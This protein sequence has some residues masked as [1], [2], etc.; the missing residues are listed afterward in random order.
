MTS[1]PAA[2]IISTECLFGAGI[3]TQD[4]SKRAQ[5]LEMLRSHQE[6]TGWPA[7]DLGE[8]LKLEWDGI[9]SH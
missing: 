5:I 3:N 4:S 2:T 7:H 1:D 6:I 8:D 9:A